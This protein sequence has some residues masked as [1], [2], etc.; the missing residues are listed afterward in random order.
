M[1][2]VIFAG[3]TGVRKADAA[4]QVAVRALKE[5]GQSLDP[6]NVNSRQ[7]VR[8]YD[9]ERELEKKYHLPLWTFLTSLNDADQ[10]TKW[11]ETFSAILHEIDKEKPQHVLLS[12]HIT[13]FKNSRFFSLLGHE[14]IKRF[15]PDL[16]VTFIDDL[17]AVWARIENKT[18]SGKDLGQS[19]LKLREILAWRT[20]EIL[21]TDLIASNLNRSNYVVAIKHPVD[22]MFRLIFKPQS[23]FIYASF[24]ITSTRIEKQRRDEIDDFRNRLH[25]EYTVFDPLTID[26]RILSFSLQKKGKRKAV[27]E[28]ADRWPI[29]TGFSM[30]GDD[31]LLF[32][33]H[34]K[35]S[36]IEE[37]LTDIDENVKFRDY[38]LVKQCD[39]LVSYRPYYK[40]KIHEGVK[41]EIDFATNLMKER[42]L[43]FPKEDG[44]KN[45]SPFKA[46]GIPYRS[47][48]ELYASLQKLQPQSV[49]KWRGFQEH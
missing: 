22:M 10:R 2:R 46:G 13:F 27:I 5:A 34:L 43:F 36:E 25:K 28:Q 16:F 8:F 11:H 14:L 15:N 17:Y 29:P 19:H 7:F 20:V 33:I 40:Q 42:Y 37:V 18:K 48:E 26:E 44:E 12:M 30:V 45:A 39:V 41:S 6:D 38:R 49:R 32:P 24:P 9:F 21:V 31:D 35:S 23:V 1:V 4:R 3:T 47:L